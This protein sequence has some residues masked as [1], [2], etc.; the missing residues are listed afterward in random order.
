MAS[1]RFE[2]ELAVTADAAT[3]WT[4]LTDVVRLATWVTVLDD[5]DEIT[6]LAKYT[7]VLAD[8]VGPFT[9][10]ATLDIVVDVLADGRHVRIRANGQD[11]QVGSQITVDAELR[12]AD[13]DGGTTVAVAGTYNVTGRVATLGGGVIKKKANKILEEFFANAERELT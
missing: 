5:V 2:R 1:Q 3:C 13:R 7:A 9:L 12:L 6:R 8:Q 10:K 4:T 11:R